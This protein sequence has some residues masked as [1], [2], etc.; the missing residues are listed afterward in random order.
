MYKTTETLAKE[1]GLVS[2]DYAVPCDW[3][4]HGIKLTG[5]NM[6][7][8]VWSYDPKDGD[9]KNIFGHPFA[10]DV[11]GK[12]FLAAY[13]AAETNERCFGENARCGHALVNECNATA[14]ALDAAIEELKKALPPTYGD[15]IR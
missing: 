7:T 8:V 5:L 6:G 12:L 2:F 15:T 11:E 10:L 1:A 4:K 9:T 3:M 14:A 13:E